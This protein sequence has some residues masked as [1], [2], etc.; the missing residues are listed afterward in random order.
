M[1]S[2]QTGTKVM[3]PGAQRDLELQ[4]GDGTNGRKLG[5]LR[6]FQDAQDPASWPGLRDA[7]N[8]SAENW[9][10]LRGVWG[11]C[12][13]CARCVAARIS[14]LEPR[15]IYVEG[16]WEFERSFTK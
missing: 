5:S 14:V 2:C 7:W 8:E 3:T 10:K 12:A 4:E 15:E 13:P 11:V 6:E 9:E 16:V 1:V